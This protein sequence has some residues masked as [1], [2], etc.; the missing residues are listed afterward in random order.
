MT[1]LLM[2]R[3]YSI[4]N[5]ASPESAENPLSILSTTATAKK[6]R[7]LK[8]IKKARGHDTH[9]PAIFCKF[10]TNVNSADI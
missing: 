5:S 10:L 7:C 9:G 1:G 6:Y 3:L 8:R 2:G 4:K